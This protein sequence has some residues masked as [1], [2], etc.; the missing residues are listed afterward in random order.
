LKSTDWGD[1]DVLILDLPPGTGDVQLGVLQELQLSGAIAV[2]TPSKLA[3]ADTRKGIEMFTSLGVPTL[4]VVENMSYFEVSLH[5]FISFDEQKTN[6]HTE[7]S[8]L[9]SKDERGKKYHLF[10]KGFIEGNASHDVMTQLVPSDAVVQVPISLITNDANDSGKPLT[11]TRPLGEAEKELDSYRKLGKLVS[12]ELLSLQY[13]HSSKERKESVTFGENPDE[14]DVESVSLSLN[15]PTNPRAEEIFFVV[16]L[17][18]ESGAV[19]FEVSPPKLRASDPRTGDIIPDSPYWSDDDNY[20]KLDPMV[21]VTKTQQRKS[22]SI[23]PT[24]VSRRGRYGFAV[25]WQDG[26][27]IIYSNRCIAKCAGGLISMKQ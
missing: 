20:S 8:D 7:Q 17:F 21:I 5:I 3:V 6:R 19:Q 23:V 14:F 15:S 1:L 26:A 25:V 12:R 13:G 16:R 24:S 9:Y 27:T 2:T 18:S 10:G 22:P 11:M 4:A